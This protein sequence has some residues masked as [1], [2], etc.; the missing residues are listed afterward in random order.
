MQ[1]NKSNDISVANSNYARTAMT[2]SGGGTINTG[3]K[4]HHHNA[5]QS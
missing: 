2:G 3:D 5:P 4:I 1:G